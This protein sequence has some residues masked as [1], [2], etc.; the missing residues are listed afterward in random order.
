[1]SHIATGG[2]Q[3]PGSNSSQK[4]AAA[5]LNIPS[6]GEVPNPAVLLAIQLG[7]GALALLP[8]LT[9]QQFA[10]VSDKLYQLLVCAAVA[11]VVIS[12]A[13][14]LA[15]YTKSRYLRFVID[16][17]GEIGICRTLICYDMLMLGGL[18]C[19][20]GGSDR[21]AFVPQFAAVLPMAV[22]IRDT[23]AMKW[24]Y[25]VVFLFMFLLGL[26]TDPNFQ[27][28]EKGEAVKERWSIV[29]F[30]VFTLFPVIYSIQT[31]RAD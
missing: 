23:P 2:N 18:V 27:F 13:L 22:L 5:S 26:G 14:W 9:L 11:N 28:L 7:G 1:M 25:A 6:P 31:E 10:N 16:K 30:F 29:F 20:T 24:V 15:F 4:G 21:S 19:L 17:I 3:L 12:G 8:I